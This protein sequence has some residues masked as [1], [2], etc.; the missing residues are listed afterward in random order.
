MNLYQTTWPLKLLCFTTIHLFIKQV[1]I[2]KLNLNKILENNKQVPI[3]KLLCAGSV[4]S[5]EALQ[6]TQ[7]LAQTDW[8]GL[9]ALSCSL[10]DL[11]HIPH[12]SLH[13]LS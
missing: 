13:F 5:L 1:P 7:A 12:L 9:T 2:H 11:G 8:V 3:Q 6:Q 4:L 10:G